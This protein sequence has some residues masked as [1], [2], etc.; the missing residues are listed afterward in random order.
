MLASYSVLERSGG[1]Q[2][3]DPLDHT[4][5]FFNNS[6]THLTSHESNRSLPINY[7]R[8]ACAAYSRQLPPHGGTLSTAFQCIWISPSPSRSCLS[9]CLSKIKGCKK[10]I[11]GARITQSDPHSTSRV[12]HSRGRP[13]NMRMGP[14]NPT[15][16]GQMAFALTLGFGT[17]PTA[18]G[19]GM[20]VA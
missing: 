9:R 11:W 19:G 15:G 16:K 18:T 7:S 1:K 20:Q 12:S 17:K 13:I 3:F 4:I 14:P 8:T 6:L 5:T 10:G 2:I